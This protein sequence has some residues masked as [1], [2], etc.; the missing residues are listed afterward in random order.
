MYRQR[1]LAAEKQLAELRGSCEST[2]SALAI[3][4]ESERRY[5]EEAGQLRTELST[6]NTTLLQ[7]Q[8]PADV[9]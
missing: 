4:I 2:K 7:V 6:T 1:A 5:A 3:A 9:P 8:V